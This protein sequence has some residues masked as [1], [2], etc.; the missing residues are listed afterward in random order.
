MRCQPLSSSLSL[1]TAASR[2]CRE[3]AAPLMARANCWSTASLIA[4]VTSTG[5]SILALASDLKA[6]TFAS[7]A[8]VPSLLLKNGSSADALV[9]GKMLVRWA[10]AAWF[11]ALVTHRARAS[12]VGRFLLFF[13]TDSPCTYS[14]GVPI[15]VD[16]TTLG[17]NVGLSVARLV[18]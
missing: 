5:C 1:A 9:L 18:M 13:D 3:V 7:P 10:N 16:G 17:A 8:L 15:A 12:A 11:P 6:M 4:C 14:G 2:A